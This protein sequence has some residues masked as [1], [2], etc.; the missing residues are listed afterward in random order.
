VSFLHA[1][2][3]LLAAAQRATCRALARGALKPLHTDTQVLSDGGIDF[4]V[5]CLRP[6]DRAH[7]AMAP[8][9]GNPFLPYDPDLYVA[10]ISPTHVALLNKFSVMEHHLLL[11]SRAFV[12]QEAPLTAA[13]LGAVRTCLQQVDAL[14]FYNSGPVAGASQRHRHLQLVPLS[15]APGRPALPV[16][17]LIAAVT[18]GAAAAACVP[19]LPYAHRLARWPGGALPPAR[20]LLATLGRLQAALGPLAA[21]PYNLLVTRQWLLLV[22]RCAERFETISVNALGFAGALLVRDAQ[23]LARVRQVGPCRLLRAVSGPA[24][25]SHRA[26][27][28]P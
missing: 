22:P 19:G 23:E 20:T 10:Q 12:P 26:P 17:P 27:P 21:A 11:V 7:P 18:P 15:A 16:A 6:E 24:A 9:S 3:A 28:S 5:R 13:D 25:A 1:P 8:S 2:G 14:A 4:L